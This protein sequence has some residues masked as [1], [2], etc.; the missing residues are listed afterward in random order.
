MKQ[1]RKFRRIPS[2]TLYAIGW[3]TPTEP[4]RLQNRP[5]QKKIVFNIQRTLNT[6]LKM[7]AGARFELTTFGL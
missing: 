5:T 1:H 3:N 6:I 2:R 4:G 7:V